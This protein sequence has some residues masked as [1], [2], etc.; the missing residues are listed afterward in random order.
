MTLKNLF[1]ATLSFFIIIFLGQNHI[2]SALAVELPELTVTPA[3]PPDRGLDAKQREAI[4][5]LV[6]TLEDKQT[7]HQLVKD[8]QTL[9]LAD[10]R[11]SPK[12]DP[13]PWGLK[14]VSETLHSMTS[15]I[16][17]FFD[18]LQLSNDRLS[19][20]LDDENL[21]PLILETF[22]KVVGIFA[23]CI[24][25]DSALNWGQRA[26]RPAFVMN[27][28]HLHLSRR[29]LIINV[30][31]VEFL[32]SMIL[33]FILGVGLYWIQPTSVSQ[34][35]LRTTLITSFFYITFLHIIRTFFYRKN[36]LITV[37]YLNNSTRS[38]VYRFLRF[39]LLTSAVGIG[40]GHVISDVQGPA[41]FYTALTKTIL[42]SQCFSSITFILRV[43]EQVRQWLMSGK[44]FASADNEVGKLYGRAVRTWHLW[45]IIYIFVFGL[46][47]YFQTIN[48]IREVITSFVATAFLVTVAY[49]LV[50]KMPTMTHNMLA[51][52]VNSFPHI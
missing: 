36:K 7:R 18:T 10:S 24:A 28:R 47:T 9:L 1:I 48:D 45:A 6:K 16:F 37:F 2:T 13:S 3:T 5:D 31:I 12:H 29:R 27:A 11:L 35:I 22:Y 30:M 4:K 43:K 42:L 51:K 44:R 33:F 26:L 34:D 49:L 52:V 25:F 14:T 21:S 32:I 41:I 17:E 15:K 20:Y 38:L 23:L 19:D 50:L 40:V 46:T 8:L 39:I